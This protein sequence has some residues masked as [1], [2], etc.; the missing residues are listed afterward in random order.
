MSILL[1]PVVPEERDL[2][3]REVV[4]RE[5]PVAHRVV[6]VVVDVGDAVDDPDDLAL[7]RRRLLRAGM[8]EDPVADLVR[9]VE[10]SGDPVGLLVVPEAAA[11]APSQ[12]LVERLLSRM[13]ERGVAHVVPE[14]DRLD[15]VFVQAQSPRH[16]ARDRGRLERVGH[17]RPVV[18]A[19]RDR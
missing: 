7:L 15:Q 16:D 3:D 14:A 9:E 11:E 4:L 12:R 1:A 17:A 13:P 5:Q 10:A 6:D 8:R 2:V 19:L 18:V